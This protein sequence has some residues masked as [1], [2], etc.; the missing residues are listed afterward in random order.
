MEQQYK[1][2]DNRIKQR[3]G[4]WSTIL[5]PADQ[6]LTRTS[7]PTTS[8]NISEPFIPLIIIIN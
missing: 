7:D 5:D 4:I 3:H 8:V 1:R 6:F 2:L